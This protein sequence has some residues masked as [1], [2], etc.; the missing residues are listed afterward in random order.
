MAGAHFKEGVVWTASPGIQ[1][2][3]AGGRFWLTGKWINVFTNGRHE[4]GVSGRA[5]FQVTPSLRLF[6]GAARAPDLTEGRVIQ[7]RSVFAGAVGTINRSLEIRIS[8]ANDAPSNGLS[9]RT[10][11]AGLGIPLK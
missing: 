10:I 1:Q 9:R 8:I 6:G 7:T 4:G 3:A 2:Y 5:D 11:S